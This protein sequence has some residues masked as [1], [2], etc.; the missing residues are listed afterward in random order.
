MINE[1]CK[2]ASQASLL[3]R[4]GVE[5]HRE[6]N[7]DASLISMPEA[8]DL[9]EVASRR[10]FYSVEILTTAPSHLTSCNMSDTVSHLFL[11]LTCPEDS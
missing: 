2:I 10:Y 3:D 8:R 7:G 5:Q 6:R 4:Q 1:W 11:I 9:A